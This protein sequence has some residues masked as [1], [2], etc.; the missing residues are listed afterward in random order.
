MQQIFAMSEIPII[1]SE[2]FVAYSQC[3]RKAFLLLFSEDRGQPHEY[4]LILGKR[5][6]DSRE[7]YL[8]EFLKSHPK[9]KGYET[10]TFKKH[11]YLIDATLRSDQLEAYCA[12]LTQVDT[13]TP[14]SRISYEPTIVVSTYS[15]TP[16]QKTELLF[17]GL[18][19]GRIQKEP[20]TTGKIVGMDGKSHRVRLEN[21]YKDIKK[22]L[23]IIESWCKKSI[24]EPP[25]LILNKNCQSCQFQQLCQQQA[26]KEGNLSLLDRMTAKAIQKYNKRGIFTI[27]QLSY[28]F[29]PRRKRKKKKEAEPVKHSLELQALAIREQKIYIQGM[30]DLIR[31]P[32]ELFLDIEGIPDQR[33]HYLIGL[34]VCE[35]EK[36]V[37]HSFWA[38]I[39]EEEEAIWQKL[40]AKLNEYSGAPIYHYGNYELKA[41]NELTKK[42]AINAEKIEKRLINVNSYIYGKIYFPVFSNRLKEIGSLLGI[43]WPPPIFSGLQS[44]AWRCKWEENRNSK[45]KNNLLVYNEKDCNALKLL[46]NKL[47]EVA[48]QEHLNSNIAFAD[49]KRLLSTE[50]GKDIH[51][52]LELILKSSHADYDRK[53]ISLRNENNS[54]KTIQKEEKKKGRGFV[55]K[56]PS[57]VNKIIEVPTVK[58]CKKCSQ[59]LY[60]DFQKPIHVTIIDLIFTK[61][62]CKKVIYL[63]KSFK[64]YCESCKLYFV[65]DIFSKG[66]GSYIFGHGFR[67]WAVYQRISLRLSYRLI[68][69]N[70]IEMFGEPIGRNS[71]SNFLNYFAVK[72]SDSEKILL[73]KILTAPFIHADETPINIQGVN[74][75]VW[76]F[77][78][79]DHVVFKLTKTR[80][81][82][83]VHKTLRK[84]S[85]VLVS[86]FYAG[87]D[88]VSCKQQKCW[89][90]LLRDINDDLW[91]SPFDSEYEAFVLELKEL[92]LPIFEAI[93]KYGLKKRN[94]G[95]YRKKVDQ[96][97]KNHITSKNYQSEL[98]IK[99]QKRFERYQ[100][101]LFTFLEYDSI[102]WHNNT[103]ERAL[104]HIAIQRKISGS[105]FETGANS[106][107]T[108]LGIMQTCKFQEKSFLK[109]LVSGEKDVDAF[110]SPKIKKRTQKIAKS[111]T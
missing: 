71:I 29:K 57:K 7:Q 18:V 52:H 2:I 96:F 36:S 54:K 101:S 78:N 44:L 15:I 97:Y 94:L 99:Y 79:G 26:E 46:V 91:K 102:P 21:G 86:D 77:T 47:T 100:K 5:R 95:K 16:E 40:L 14:N 17:I 92:I 64:S 37:Q 55:R 45:Y 103:A 20:P 25:A 35:G 89:V 19:L 68:V 43:T 56:A 49:Q 59:E 66:S 76:T 74:Q 75:Y 34:L 4:P 30:P 106:Y 24:S 58:A 3:P 109:F 105:F 6:Q 83:I 98:S 31:H 88:S 61:S 32:V 73:D 53:K 1:T 67:S 85:G 107:L 65:P 72:Y 63:H 23:K 60:Q 10:K 51:F 22:S 50:I 93:D 41:I 87:Y 110:K 69:Q 80:E 70:S 62:G 48:N 82:D 42:Y 12:V 90:H 38:D 13:N 104:R 28:L 81:A 27:Q 11:E 108:L 9:A 8:E 39:P 84:Y 33:F 111:H